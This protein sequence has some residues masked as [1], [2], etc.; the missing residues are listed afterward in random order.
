[1]PAARETDTPLERLDSLEPNETVAASVQWFDAH[2]QAVKST[3]RVKGKNRSVRL[4]EM[5]LKAP[6]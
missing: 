6:G 5:K 1:M 4:D 2:T 3:G